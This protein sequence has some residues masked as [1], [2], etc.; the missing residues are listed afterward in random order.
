MSY[1]SKTIYWKDYS[2]TNWN[3]LWSLSQINWLRISSLF[4][5]FSFCSID[6]YVSPYANISSH[7]YLSFNA[8][9]VLLLFCF[10]IAVVG[11][12]PYFCAEKRYWSMPDTAI[13]RKTCLQRLAL[14]WHLGTWISGGCPPS[15]IHKSDSPRLN[16]GKSTV[17]L[18][19]WVLSGSLK[20]WCVLGRGTYLTNPQ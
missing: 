7:V 8:W 19:I 9:T 14:G 12:L 13:L 6:L 18:N 11:F 4:L 16:C 10:F 2:F 5:D 1:Y 15:L 20:V 17:T 3:T